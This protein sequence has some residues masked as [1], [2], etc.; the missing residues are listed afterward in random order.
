MNCR[1]TAV[2]AVVVMVLACTVALAPASE[3]DAGVADVRQG[4]AWGFGG[5]MDVD[6]IVDVINS[7]S[8]TQIPKPSEILTQL[9]QELTGSGY[10]V[11]NLFANADASLWGI[12]EITSK[13]RDSMTMDI[14][15]AASFSVDVA[16]DVTGPRPAH[17][18]GQGTTTMGDD[19]R[20]MG[21]VFTTVYVLASG[22]AHMDDNFGISYMEMSVDLALS[23]DGLS[24]VRFDLDG[25]GGADISYLEKPEAVSEQLSMCMDVT[26]QAVDGVIQM[27]PEDDGQLAWGG[28]VPVY[29]SVT[30]SVYT[31]DPS[32]DGTFGMGAT[33]PMTYAGAYVKVGDVY[34]VT[35]TM[36]GTP[37]TFPY[38]FDAMDR[39]IPSQ[40]LIG[41]TMVLDEDGKRT[42]RDS[43]SEITDDYDEAMSDIGLT[44]TFA[45]RDG[46][47]IGTREV[48]F[49]D[50]VDLPMYQ[51]PEGTVFVGWDAGLGAEWSAN[52]PVKSDITLYPIVAKVVDSRP[53]PGDFGTGAV[54]WRV[55]GGSNVID[56]DLL[57]MGT[58]Y[59][60][61]TDSDGNTVFA[62]RFS[63]GS[64]PEGT[65]MDTGITRADVP[66][67]VA[68]RFSGMDVVYLDF[69]ASGQMPDGTSIAYNVGATFSDGETV[70]FYNITDDGEAVYSGSATVDDGW[71]ELPLTHCSS[72]A[73]VGS[74]SDGGGADTATLAVVAAVIV[75]VVLIVLI[76][77]VVRRRNH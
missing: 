67:S 68:D 34:Y 66:Q 76:A 31:G 26:M 69:A 56:G 14:D 74:H 43:I 3:T 36:D 50:T 9:R 75:V 18:D 15:M 47:V 53:T 41:G 55:D 23:L 5:D 1:L 46:N 44:V 49:G 61:G 57:S 45:E 4:D 72:Y 11:D 10:D 29:S 35:V 20:I 12:N 16:L 28:T 65:V 58:L 39:Y 7:V 70:S 62:W 17:I 33:V 51:A 2:A 42:I 8:S 30:A 71:V 32:V 60:T 24:N 6:K 48:M 77:F 38:P 27:L 63:G 59:V 54:E 19:G 37:T 21:E 13:D 40:L 25:E 52:T 73:I 22:T 64:I